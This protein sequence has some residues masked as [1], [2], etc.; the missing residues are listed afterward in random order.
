MSLKKNLDCHAEIL[1]TRCFRQFV[2]MQVKGCIEEKSLTIE[3]LKFDET[4]K[5]FM[6]QEG[7][8]LQLYISFFLVVIAG[9]P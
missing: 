9:I 4:K 3:I 1:T 2:M 8:H 5:T 7:Y 6:L